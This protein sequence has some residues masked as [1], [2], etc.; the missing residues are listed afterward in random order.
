MLTVAMFGIE[1]DEQFFKIIVGVVLALIP[2]VYAACFMALR[3]WHR[4]KDREAERERI[5]I[6]A[7]LKE[8]MVDRGMSADEIAKVL[9]ARLPEGEARH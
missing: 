2:L 8:K 7:D 1:S 4:A 5:E 3:A 6:E 9:S